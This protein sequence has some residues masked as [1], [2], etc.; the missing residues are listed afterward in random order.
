MKRLLLLLFTIATIGAQDYSLYFDGEG[1]DL[2]LT[3]F[4]PI[5]GNDER[6]ITFWSKHSFDDDLCSTEIG[7]GMLNYGGVEAYGCNGNK[8]DIEFG[9]WD[10]KYKI[11]LDIGCQTI[12]AEINYDN[13]WHHYAIVIPQNAILTDISF[14]QD[15]MMLNN[16]IDVLPF[17]IN[18][19]SEATL[20]IGRDNEINGTNLSEVMQYYKGFIDELAFWNYTFSEFDVEE[21]LN[22]NLIENEYLMEK[23]SF[24][25][26]LE[27]LNGNVGYGDITYSENIYGCTDELATNYNPDANWND[28]S[29]TYPD[30]GDYSLSFDGVDDYVGIPAFSGTY[31]K[32]SFNIELELINGLSNYPTIFYFGTEA[33]ANNT[34][35]RTI[36]LSIDG[37][38]HINNPQLR[39]NLNYDYGRVGTANFNYN[40]PIEIIGLFDGE[41]QNLQLYLNGILIEPNIDYREVTVNEIIFNILD[42]IYF[43]GKGIN[44]FNWFSGKINNLIFLNRLITDEEINGNINYNE[45]SIA[46]YKFNAGSGDILYDYSGNGNHGTIHGAKWTYEFSE[47]N[48]NPLIS[49]NNLISLPG[50]P[51]N[52]DSQY[53]GNT[54]ESPIFIL[55]QGQG[56]FNTDDGWSGNLTTMD[57]LRGYWVNVGIAQ[58]WTYHLDGEAVYAESNPYNLT[59][60]NNLVSYLGQDGCPTMDV[61]LWMH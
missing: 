5:T 31:D 59:S 2:F 10:D 36:D 50:T 25:N 6:T 8:I 17:E 3:D 35:T 11:V 61:L 37:I 15:A 48:G 58:D 39:V 47:H 34:F 40:K 46:H 30:N 49:G 51:E 42:G 16:N 13:N 4:Y 57:E 26:N 1:S 55:G 44:D 41:N 9:C 23:W 7:A 21:L 14:Y 24:N 43:I 19:T 20:T 38:N 32:L 12:N 53:L 54:M 60:G 27:G 18:T 52:D 45:G 56:L 33:G 28:G 22:N 29:C